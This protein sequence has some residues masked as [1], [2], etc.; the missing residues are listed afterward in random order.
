MTPAQ[1]ALA[2]LLAQDGVIAIPKTG[3]RDRLEENAAALE[4]ALDAEQMR[5]L[6]RLFRPP[7]GPSPLAML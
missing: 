5:E 3:R 7:A 2:W 6:D 4:H 1:V